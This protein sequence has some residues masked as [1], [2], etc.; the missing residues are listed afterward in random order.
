VP[1]QAR[2]AQLRRELGRGRGRVGLRGRGRVRGS[3]R[4][5]GRGSG[6]GRV[7]VRVRGRGRG[8]LPVEGVVEARGVAAGGGA[9]RALVVGEALA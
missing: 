4:G 8:S 9:E 1:A 2:E 7:R 6:R 5:R 3:G